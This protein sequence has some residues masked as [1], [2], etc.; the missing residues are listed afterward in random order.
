M[1]PHLEESGSD[2]D[3]FK[4]RCEMQ[5]KTPYLE[6]RNGDKEDIFKMRCKILG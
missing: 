3:V 4:M 1:S 5:T 6:E 2:E